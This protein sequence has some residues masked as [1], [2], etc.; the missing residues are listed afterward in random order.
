MASQL[1]PVE[2]AIPYR[3][4]NLDTSASQTPPGYARE[5]HNIICDSP[6]EMRTR[7]GWS[8]LQG[9]ENIYTDQLQ[10]QLI[11]EC[12]FPGGTNRQTILNLVESGTP[13]AGNYLGRQ[14]STSIYSSAINRTGYLGTFSSSFTSATYLPYVLHPGYFYDGDLFLTVDD[15]LGSGISWNPYFK[16]WG[17]VTTNVSHT[18]GGVTI[19]NGSTTGTFSVAPSGKNLTGCYLRLAS[20]GPASQYDY[21]Y[22]I[23][24]HT[25]GSTSFT[26]ARPYGLGEST[27]NVP[28][29]SSGSNTVDVRPFQNVT[30]YGSPHGR[31]LGFWRERLFVDDAT[32][33]PSAVIKWS[34]PAEPLKWFPTNEAKLD[35]SDRAVTGFAPLQD[36]MLIFTD[37]QT[38]VMS[39]WDEDSFVI[40]L[41][42]PTIGC[43]DHRSI[44]YWRGNVIWAAADGIYMS[45][46]SS[47]V[48]ELTNTGGYGIREAYRQRVKSLTQGLR[49]QMTVFEERLYV[50]AQD[51]DVDGIDPRPAYM[52]D[53]RTRS[54]FTFGNA[55]GGRG[56]TEL[57]AA[58]PITNLF[59]ARDQKLGGLSPYFST[60]IEACYRGE[61]DSN[62]VNDKHDRTVTSAETRQDV[63][64]AVV[65]FPD[66]RL[67]GID[68]VRVRGVQVEHNCQYVNG[69]T[70]PAAAWTVTLD[71]DADVDSSSL[72]VGDVAARQVASVSFEKYFTDRF[73]GTSFPTEGAVFRV[74]MSKA[75]TVNSAKVFRVAFLA[76]GQPTMLGRVDLTQT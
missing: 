11:G 26:L 24:N 13:I 58:Y 22:R 14:D 15:D 63:I 59:G 38:F 31:T 45:N 30:R 40:R 43:L 47:D 42:Y 71:V 6:T 19:N 39:G 25:T 33:I 41:L 49:V 9:W 4:L 61:D 48:V 75:A 72:T 3:G 64:E 74:K 7:R 23:A 34:Q 57:W 20:G 17:G 44:C 35:T 1:Q 60:S 46:G 21:V 55:T 50:F 5:A 27:T 53:L 69:Q 16:V 70:S 18:S 36:I 29:V 8:G 52:C 32:Q 68:T 66:V 51:L 37:N 2:L 12:V 65:R 73:T 56:R 62:N 28:N 76:D 10:A 67:G 54:W